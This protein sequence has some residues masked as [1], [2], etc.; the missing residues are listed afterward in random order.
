MKFLKDI[1]NPLRIIF[2]VIII[3][4][5][6]AMLATFYLINGSAEINPETEFGVTFS[7]ITAEEMKIDWKNAYEDIIDDL[8][9]KK[10]RLIAYWPLIEKNK[11]EY[12]F[13][14]LDWQINKAKENEVKIILAVGSK[15]PGYSGS[16]LPEWA[17]EL[18][19]EEKKENALLFIKEVVAHY[20]VEETIKVWQIENNP[21]QKS[22]E[23]FLEI[24]KDFLNQEISL[25]R[26][27]DFLRRPI[28][29]TVKNKLSNWFKPAAS[30]DILG[31]SVYENNWSEY[32]NYI[33]IPVNPIFYK[34]MSGLVKYLT[35]VDNIIIIDFQA[36]PRGPKSI[37]KMTSTEWEKSMSLL[38]FKESI[39]YAKKTG[40]DE[41]Y[42]TGAEWWY[43]LKKD[44]NNAFW[45]EAKNLWSK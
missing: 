5:I 2:F 22:L 28:M 21:F 41:I 15:L 3:L 36:E 1:F 13:D 45:D 39:I 44:G 24:D 38:K 32:I 33:N 29:L 9:V 43:H 30:S 4:I 18:N 31:I 34:K 14:D 11:G 42:L 35:D 17:K 12:S 7:Q 10:I 16:Y 25:V 27:T 20:N 37:S 40:F 19:E 8:G 23:N 6:I 26:E